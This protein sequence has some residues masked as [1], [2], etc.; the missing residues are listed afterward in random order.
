MSGAPSIRTWHS[1]RFLSA[2]FMDQQSRLG[3]I[4]DQ[5]N[6]SAGLQSVFLD[7]ECF[8]NKAAG[9]DMI[10]LERQQPSTSIDST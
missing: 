7:W 10:P 6:E 1:A 5:S 3:M 8:G 4:N 2:R 9:Y